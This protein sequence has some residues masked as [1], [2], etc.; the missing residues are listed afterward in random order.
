MS[1]SRDNGTMTPTLNGAAAFNGLQ[2]ND[3]TFKSGNLGM[4]T[5]SPPI[6]DTSV[7]L[8]ND[9]GGSDGFPLYGPWNFTLDGEFIVD[10]PDDVQAAINDLRSTFNLYAGSGLLTFAS[11]GFS[12]V[13]RMT[14]RLN[15]QIV[16][17]DPGK[18]RRKSRVRQYSIPMLAVDPRAYDD[19]VAD[20][21]T[22]TVPIGTPTA[23]PNGGNYPTPISIEFVGKLTSPSFDG[24]GT[25]GFNRIRLANQ[26]G[27]DYVV[28]AGHSV[29]VQTFVS[30]P[31]GVTALLDG[32][33]NVYGKVANRSAG[34]IIPGTSNYTLSTDDGTD[35][36]H[37]VV[38]YRDAWV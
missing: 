28:A 10:S 22:I 2:I 15:G 31:A 29:T 1:Y 13:R 23:L 26:D 37:A 18:G 21:H 30:G 4:I 25:A 24:P 32:S 36:G 12:G 6:L 33:T 3:G 14:A 27:S 7:Q 34:L 5:G 11:R 19:D 9:D 16:I 20:L 35:T 38:T 8:P 17:N